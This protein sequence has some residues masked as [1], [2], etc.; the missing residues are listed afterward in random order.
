[1]KKHFRKNPVYLRISADFEVDNEVDN[2]SI[3]NKTTNI[4][5]QNAVLNVYRIESEW[6]NIL[7]IGYY[8]SPLGYNNV[9]WF[10]I[11]VVKLEKNGFLF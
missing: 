4:Y 7:K 11:E 10:V 2:S 3:R 8:K 1:M 9:D 5:K 6:D